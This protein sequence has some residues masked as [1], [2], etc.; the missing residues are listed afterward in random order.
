MN[1]QRGRNLNCDDFFPKQNENTN[2]ATFKIR[3]QKKKN[4]KKPKE[5]EEL[6]SSSLPSRKKATVKSMLRRKSSTS[7]SSQA[8]V[9]ITKDLDRLTRHFPPQLLKLF[10]K[11]QTN[12]R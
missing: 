12:S 5:E 9:E 2:L 1:K 10:F 4:K 6:L 11:N 8:S 3:N 7:S